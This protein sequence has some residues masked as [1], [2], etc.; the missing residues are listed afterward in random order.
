M[1][2]QGFAELSAQGVGVGEGDR[3]GQRHAAVQVVSDDVVESRRT[4][5]Q[6]VDDLVRVASCAAGVQVVDENGKSQGFV[7]PLPDLKGLDGVGL[8]LKGGGAAPCRQASGRCTTAAAIFSNV[9]N[10]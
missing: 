3:L 1:A 6:A 4:S 5:N 2:S 10:L 7:L 8:D 9:T